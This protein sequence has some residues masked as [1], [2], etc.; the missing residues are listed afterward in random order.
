MF[1]KISVLIFFSCA[2]VA[3][4]PNPITVITGPTLVAP[5]AQATFT[6]ALSGTS[7]TI[8][9]VQNTLS[10]SLTNTPLT[11]GTPTLLV[12]KTTFC[13]TPTSAPETCMVAGVIPPPVISGG[14][15]TIPSTAIFN[16]TPIPDGTTIENITLTVP[17]TATPN[18]TATLTTT[19]TFAADVNGVAVSIGNASFT[20]TV[21][22]QYSQAIVVATT[23]YNLWVS[24]PTQP[25]FLTLIK[26][27]A[28]AQSLVGK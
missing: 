24:A 26:A 27:L 15:V 19:N 8:A 21:G 9:A 28:N 22:T 2:L 6:L 4:T 3:Q 23:D 1:K 7:G 12:S 5:G 16:N 18:S 25:N 17:S 14:T 11:V 20:F 10:T 13:F